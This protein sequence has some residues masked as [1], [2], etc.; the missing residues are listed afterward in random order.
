MR[1][2]YIYIYIYPLRDSTGHLIPS[3]PT[4]YQ[5]DYVIASLSGALPCVENLGLPPRYIQNSK[6]YT[7]KKQAQNP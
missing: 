5:A 7:S 2:L 3:F 1:A 4:K 6:N